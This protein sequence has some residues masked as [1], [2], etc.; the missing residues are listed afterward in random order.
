VQVHIEV[1]RAPESLDDHHRP[2]PAILHPAPTRAQPD[3]R[4]DGAEKRRRHRATGRVIKREH[5]TEPHRQGQHPLPDRHLGKHVVDQMCRAF[6]HPPRATA[7]TEAPALARERHQPVRAAGA[8]PEPRESRRQATAGQKLA[9]LALDKRGQPLSLP[10]S[11]RSR[12]Q[13]LEVIAD[14]ALAVRNQNDTAWRSVW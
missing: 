5:V 14:E 4:E 7:R 11:A 12:A 10:A 8:A 3:P 13:R 9:K 6:R 2:G 1:E